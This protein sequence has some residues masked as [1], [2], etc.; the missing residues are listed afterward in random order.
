MSVFG[1]VQ[2]PPT[3]APAVAELP[4]ALAALSEEALLAARE[5]EYEQ[6]LAEVRASH[7]GAAPMGRHGAEGSGEEFEGEA[8]E[9]EDDDTDQAD[10]DDDVTSDDFGQETTT[11]Q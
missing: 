10:V 5:A 8:E 1:F 3:R 6:Q 9:E 7:E 2:F 11:G 4:A